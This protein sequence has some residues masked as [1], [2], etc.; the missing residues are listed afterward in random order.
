MISFSLILHAFHTLDLGFGFFE[1][2]LGFLKI[3]EY[4]VKF[5][6][7]VICCYMLMHCITF[8]FSQYFMHLYVCFYVGNLC[9]SRIGFG[10]AHDEFFFARHMLMHYSCIHTFSFLILVLFV[11]G[12]FL[13]VSVSIS[14]SI[15]LSLSLSLSL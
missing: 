1:N 11:I 5:L 2:F 9:P 10:R 13:S 8:A 14:V 3:D 12:T 15:S 6:G 4:F 7:W